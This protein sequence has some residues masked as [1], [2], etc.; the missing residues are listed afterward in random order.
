MSASEQLKTL[1]AQMPDPDARGMYCTGVDK[2]KIERAI[3]E[4]HKGGK[5]SILGLIDMLGQPGSDQDVKPHYALHCLANFYLQTKDEDGRRQFCETLAGELSGER[6][7]Y[8][9]GYLCQELQW[10]GRSESAPA[11]GKLLCDEELS[12]P[13]AM[14]LVAIGQGAAEQFRAALGAAQGKCR[15]NVVQG[16]GAVGDP[17]SAPALQAALADE[18]REVRLAA[19][20]ALARAGDAASADLLIKAA[21]AQPGWE[22]IQA[23]KHCMLLAEKLQA[24]GK[25]AEAAKIYTYL[26]DSRSDPSEKYIRQAAEKALAG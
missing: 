12:A 11:L 5:E 21:G 6:S 3:A 4:I 26:R 1:V 22:R 20:W 7:K 17:Q 14:A 18:D 23:T 9:R 15:L 24:A 25:Q 19:G 2:Q 16:L 13:A 10:A 8:V